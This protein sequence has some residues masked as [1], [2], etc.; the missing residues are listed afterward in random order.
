MAFAQREVVG[1]SQFQFIPCRGQLALKRHAAPLT[2]TSFM[3]N[4]FSEFQNKISNYEINT[5]IPLVR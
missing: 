4:W 3:S 1:T 2:Y 5:E